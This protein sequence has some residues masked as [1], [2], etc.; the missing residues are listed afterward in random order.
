MLLKCN[1]C[2]KKIITIIICYTMMTTFS[3]TVHR[4]ICQAMTVWFLD[5]DDILGVFAGFHACYVSVCL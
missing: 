4:F 1:Q 2:L 3:V 5:M